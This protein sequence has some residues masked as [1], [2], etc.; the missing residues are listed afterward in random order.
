MLDEIRIRL[1]QEIDN[2]GLSLAAASRAAGEP[3]PQRLKDVVSGRQK[4][5]A[6]LLANLIHIG[7]DSFYVLTG[8]KSEAAIS[9]E[10]VR[11]LVSFRAADVQV[12]D[13]VLRALNPSNENI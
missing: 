11:L 10:E 3:S 4:C 7:V 2:S 13:A 5:T 9:P 6:D 12:K 1:R 8:Q